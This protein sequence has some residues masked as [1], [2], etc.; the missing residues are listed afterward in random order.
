MRSALQGWKGSCVRDGESSLMALKLHLVVSSAQTED[1]LLES[2]LALIKE[3]MLSNGIP[4]ESVLL[5]RVLSQDCVYVISL[6]GLDEQGR[7]AM[8]SM[9]EHLNHQT[10]EWSSMQTSG[11]V[12][13]AELTFLD[14]RGILKLI[15]VEFEHRERE[16]SNLSQEI[17]KL[18][19]DADVFDKLAIDREFAALEVAEKR[20]M[21][22]KK[23]VTALVRR[24][25]MFRC[26][27]DFIL[28]L[29]RESWRV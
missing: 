12:E 9:V 2:L 19:N 27:R 18:R 17:Q 28:S 4:R 8:S 10:G 25:T 11:A 1:D 14:L 22:I 24:T 7:Q 26:W 29:R 5:V 6:S 3:R 21:S 13:S 20:M 23:L 16:V 15:V